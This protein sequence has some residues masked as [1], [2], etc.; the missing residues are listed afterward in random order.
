[1]NMAGKAKKDGQEASCIYVICG[2]DKHRVGDECGK[3]VDGMLTP[4]ER[5]MSLFAPEPDKVE[6]AEVLDELRTLPFIAA[7]RVVVLKGADNFISENRDLLEKYFD[8]PSRTGV[9]VMTVDTWRKN[10]KLAKKLIKVG[11]L[12][13]IGELKVWQLPK[14]VSEYGQGIGKGFERGAAE[15][16]VELVGDE[17][18]RLCSEVDKLAMYVGDKKTITVADV[19]SLVGHNRTFNVFAVIDALTTGNV[20]G[21]VEKLRNMFAGDKSAEFTA[22]G[23]FAFHFRRMF[24]AK[25]LITKGVNRGQ[26]IKDL[27]IWGNDAAFFKQLGEFS[28]ERI[29]AVLGELARIDHGMKTGGMT[30]KVAIEQLL[31]KLGG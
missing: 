2:K 15:M 20:G 25:V 21:A 18:G 31:F 12:I 4:D 14:Y 16:V 7:R 6:V 8:E 22:V 28:L 24:R 5:A 19:E 1:M 29:G 10:T 23:A 11:Q 27:R 30:G 17:P 9:L 3:L 13:E 26:V